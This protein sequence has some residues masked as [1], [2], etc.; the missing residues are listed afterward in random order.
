MIDATDTIRA[1]IDQFLEDIP[2]LKQGKENH[3]ER[4][5]RIEREIGRMNR[6]MEKLQAAMKQIIR[7]LDNH[8]HRLSMI[9]STH[10]PMS[11]LA[12]NMGMK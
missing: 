1:I 6:N 4:L 5:A 9:E 2:P 7:K 8:N 11:V 10:D 3:D 12:R